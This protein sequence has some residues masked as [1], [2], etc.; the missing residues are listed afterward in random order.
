M[1]FLTVPMLYGLGAVAVAA[2]IIAGVQ[3]VRLSNAK[4]IHQ[5]HLAA[6]ATATAKAQADARAKEQA[7]GERQA[8]IEAQYLKDQQDA[9]AEYDRVVAALRAG[10]LKLRQRWRCPASVPGIANTAGQPDAGA[11]DGAESAARI[12]RAAA[13]CDAQVKGLQSIVISDRAM[14]P[15][16]DR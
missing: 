13:E 5:T 16:N 15:V 6:D 2:G 11:D 4:A 9:Q 12:V 1:N 8:A 7:A 14:S 3:S 10:E